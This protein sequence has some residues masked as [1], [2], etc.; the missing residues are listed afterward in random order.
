MTG[1]AL[2]LHYRQHRP[3]TS[4]LQT[5]HDETRPV[6]V[7]G[8]PAAAARMLGWMSSVRLIQLSISSRIL[9]MHPSSVISLR[10]AIAELSCAQD[11]V[12]T[13]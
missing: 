3:H 5:S 10:R 11:H 12:R 1:P 9:G 2:E 7:I 6:I 4:Y 8:V 13:V